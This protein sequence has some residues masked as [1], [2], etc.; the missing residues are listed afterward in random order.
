L[1]KQEISGDKMMPKIDSNNDLSRENRQDPEEQPRKRAWQSP[2]VTQRGVEKTKG[3]KG[4]LFE[5][6]DGPPSSGP[7]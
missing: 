3:K 5:V 1:L 4:F 7:S 2:K 6:F